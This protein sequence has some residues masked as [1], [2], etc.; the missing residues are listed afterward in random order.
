MAK[1]LETQMEMKDARELS[2][3][4][5][6]ALLL[7][8]EL[9]TRENKTL[10]TRLKKAK[11][12]LA[13]CL[14]DLDL[15]PSRGLDRSVITSLANPDW[16]KSHQNILITG[17]TGAGKTYL[18]CALAQRACRN[19][20]YAFYF[21]APILFQDLAVAKGDGR[22]RKMLTSISKKDLI[23]LDDFALAPLTDEQRRDLLEVIEQR[24]DSKATIVVSQIPLD[25]WHQIIGDPTIADAILDRLVHNSHKLFLKGDSMRK[26]K[27]EQ[28]G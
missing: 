20:L 11:L 9:V 8:A 14:E 2:F 10:A 22:Y 5:R 24:Y 25:H 16:V 28:D 4:E 7:D 6:L 3:E 13:A 19:G 18:A 12:R 27:T 15:R 26:K 1:A 21:R 17:P 23:V